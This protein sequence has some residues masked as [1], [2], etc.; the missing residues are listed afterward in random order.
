MKYLSIDPTMRVW[1]ADVPQ[2]MPPVQLGEVMRAL[3]VAEIVESRH[4]DFKKGDKITGFTG[5][6]QFVLLTPADAHTFRKLPSIPFLA[7]Y[8]FLATLGINGLTA[9]FGLLDIGKPQPGETIVVSAAAGATG[10][11]AGQIGRIHG[12][13][14]VG[15]AGTDEKCKWIKDDLGFD[16]AINYKYPDWKENLSQLRPRVSI[17][18]SKTLADPSCKLF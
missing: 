13:H 12:C 14:V 1:M 2:Y 10:S 11:I 6:Q 3:G 9:Y 4:S 18:T 8:H 17:S 5:L 15:I 7:D 16:A